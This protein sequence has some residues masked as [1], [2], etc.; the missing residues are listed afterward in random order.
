MLTYAFTIIGTAW[1][2]LQVYAARKNVKAQ[3]AREEF[4][5]SIP[6]EAY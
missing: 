6:E 1:V 5:N 3:K 4:W 2:C